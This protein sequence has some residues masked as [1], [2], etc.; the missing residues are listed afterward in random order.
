MDKEWKEGNMRH[1]GIK[2]KKNRTRF[3]CS[4]HKT[5]VVSSQSWLGETIVGNDPATSVVVGRAM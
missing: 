4:G 3:I 2:R 1:G 5:A